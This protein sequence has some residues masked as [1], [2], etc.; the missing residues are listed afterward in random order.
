MNE[1][2]SVLTVAPGAVAVAGADADTTGPS[3]SPSPGPAPA[4][5][6]LSAGAMLRQM[7]EAAGVDAA[8]LASAMK[9]SPQK[10]EALENDRFD[11][12]PNITFAR[13]LTSAI[14]RAFGAD[15]APVLERMPVVVP[16]LRMPNNQRNQRFQRSEDRPAPMI[17]RSLSIPL[18]IAVVVLLIGAVALWLMPITIRLDSAAPPAAAKPAPNSMAAEENAEPVQAQEPAASDEAPASA[19]SA[20]QG[21]GADALAR[22]QQNQAAASAAAAS[23]SDQAATT[24]QDALVVTATGDS[25]LTVRDASGKDLIRRLLNA[26]ETV[27]INGELPLSVTI[28]RKDAVEVTVHGQLFDHKS[29]SSDSVVRFMIK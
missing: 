28:G 1:P 17:S 22:L 2:D 25:W 7:R 13:G 24:A 6:R 10:L 5:N 14:C 4:L 9:V 12:L 29:L 21:E 18:L 19:A 23:A 16:D 27:R 11:E 26:G 20:E 3:P 8:R 15:P